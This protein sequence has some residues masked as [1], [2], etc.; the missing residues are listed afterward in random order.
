M[1]VCV[2]ACVTACRRLV[3]GLW[4]CRTMQRNMRSHSPLH[5]QSHAARATAEL[6]LC[7]RHPCQPFT[8]PH[9]RAL[10][11]AAGGQHVASELLQGPRGRSGCRGSPLGRPAPVLQQAQRRSRRHSGSRLLPGTAAAAAAAWPC[12]LS[13]ANDTR[14]QEYDFLSAGVPM[15]PAPPYTRLTRYTGLFCV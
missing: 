2:H 4:S 15:L 10:A 11:A 6:L 1:R 13:H 14:D 12:R 3:S 5:L 9:M 7:L 8:V